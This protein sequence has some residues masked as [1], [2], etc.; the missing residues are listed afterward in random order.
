M[1]HSPRGTKRRRFLP[2]VERSARVVALPN[3]PVKMVGKRWEVVAIAAGALPLLQDYVI[4][5]AFGCRF[6]YVHAASLQ[7]DPP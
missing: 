5:A 6:V 1:N 3:S 2:C 7:H 4:L